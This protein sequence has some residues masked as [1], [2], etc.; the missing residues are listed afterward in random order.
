MEKPNQLHVFPEVPIAQRM[1]LDGSARSRAAVVPAGTISD[2]RR[3]PRFKVEVNMRINS[4]TCGML[5]GHSVDISESGIAATLP[6]EVPLGEKVELNFTLPSGS[7]TIH[8]I[9]RQKRAFRYGF[10]F[11]ASGSMHELIRRACRDLAMNQSL[12]CV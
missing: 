1:E 9:V 8:A 11:L 4:K 2:A 3:Q 6:I 7:V 10:E 12:R 5:K